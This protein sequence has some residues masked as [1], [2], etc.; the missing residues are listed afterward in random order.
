MALATR[1]SPRAQHRQRAR[2]DRAA[3]APAHGVDFVRAGDRQHR[4]DRLHH[5]PLEVV[6]PADVAELGPRVAPRHE[7]HRQALFA[8]EAHEGVLRLQVEDVELVDARRHDQQRPRGHLL[9]QRRVLDELQQ[10]VLV[11]H[12]A[13]GGRDVDADLER[14]LVG[15][16]DAP[17]LHV[18]EQ[19]RHARGDAL[20]AGFEREAQRLGVGGG[21]VRRAHR[22]DE[23]VREEAQLVLLAG[24]ELGGLHHLGEQPGVEQVGL[25]EQAVPRV[26]TP[27]LAVEAPVAA[28]GGHHGLARLAAGGQQAGPQGHLLLPVVRLRLRERRVGQR[29]GKRLALG[30]AVACVAPCTE[31]PHEARAGLEEALDE[32]VGH[33]EYE[34]R[35]HGAAPSPNRSGCDGAVG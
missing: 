22:V 1:L 16:G 33:L 8:R 17:L 11:D 21:E 23:L 5:A 31:G 19:V 2:K 9:G 35:S 29:P 25:L 13:R 32:L 24:V 28:L 18:V 4:V 20:A 34:W 6:V 15:D 26:A 10:I 14:A 7:E 3:H 27:V 12:R 30:G